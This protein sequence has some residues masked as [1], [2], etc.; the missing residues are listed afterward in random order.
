[1]GTS[2]RKTRL[3]VLQRGSCLAK[4]GGGTPGTNHAALVGAGPAGWKHWLFCVEAQSLR[5]DE[6]MK[7]PRCGCELMNRRCAGFGVAQSG[8]L[9]FSC[10]SRT[11]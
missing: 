4:G 1:M 8:V 5:C 7:L 11:T 3:N 9:C 10:R 2:C 6:M